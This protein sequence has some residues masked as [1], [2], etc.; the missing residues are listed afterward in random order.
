MAVELH[1]LANVEPVEVDVGGRERL[2]RQVC[3]KYIYV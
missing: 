2:Q 1:K 3:K